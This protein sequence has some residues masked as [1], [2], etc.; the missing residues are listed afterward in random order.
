MTPPSP[1]KPAVIALAAETPARRVEALRVFMTGLTV[2][3]EIGLYARERGRR[4][5]LVIA[6]EAEVEPRRVSDPDETVNYETFAARA[7]KLA[8]SGHVDLVE[9]FAQR[10]AD[11]L[12]DHPRVMR[13]RVRVDKPEAL[14]DAAQ[15]G[16]EL[17]L[18]KA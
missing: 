1:A 14:G 5:P 11:L 13:V 16:C 7:R 2:Q 3:A 12:L 8:D 10:L 17:I 9:T 15:V 6:V 18:T 4:Q